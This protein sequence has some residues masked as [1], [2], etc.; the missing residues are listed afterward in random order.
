MGLKELFVVKGNMS[1][2]PKPIGNDAEFKSIAE[3]LVEIHL[4]DCRVSG[5]I[6][7]H[8]AVGGFIR[9]KVII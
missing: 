6:G 4:L 7:K 1:D 3:M 8:G 5:D 2:D 9:V